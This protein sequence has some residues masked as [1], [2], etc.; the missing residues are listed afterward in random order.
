MTAASQSLLGLKLRAF[1]KR[2][3]PAPVKRIIKRML[4]TPTRPWSEP[5]SRPFYDIADFPFT[6]ELEAN[7]EAIRREFEALDQ[8][9]LID[10]PEEIYKGSWSVYGLYAFGE[11]LEENCGRCPVATRVIEGIPGLT[12]AGFSVLMPGSR[13]LPHLGYTNTV[14]RCHLGLI[15]P[16]GCRIRVGDQIREWEE[17]KTMVFD[18]TLEHEVWHD[19]TTPRIILLLDFVRPGQRFDFRGAEGVQPLLNTD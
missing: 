3:L 17:G 15:V 11:K 12:T 18:D 6:A 13:I 5:G 16:D 8:G 1:L 7:W 14:L 4:G 2:V 10:W 19:G 9:Q